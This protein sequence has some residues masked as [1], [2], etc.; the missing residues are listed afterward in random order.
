M[1]DAGPEYEVIK[2]GGRKAEEEFALKEF[3][4]HM[5]MTAPGGGAG[6]VALAGMPVTA[7]GG[8]AGEVAPAGMPVTAPGGKAEEGEIDSDGGVYETLP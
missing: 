6:E 1:Y 2:G 7:P 8:G 5:P 4:S 3:P